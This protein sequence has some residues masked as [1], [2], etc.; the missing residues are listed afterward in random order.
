LTA[1]FVTPNDSALFYID[2]PAESQGKFCRITKKGNYGLLFANISNFLWYAEP[3][4]LPCNKADFTIAV[5]NKNGNCITQL[6]AVSGSGPLQ[7]EVN[8]MGS[9][10]SFSGQQLIELPDYSSPNAVV[11][12]T[13]GTDCSLTKRVGDDPKFNKSKEACAS[14]A[15]LPEAA[16]KPAIYPNPSTGIFNCSQKNGTVLTADEIIISNAQ[17][18]RMGDFKNVQQFNLSNV[19]AGLYWYKMIIKGEE[20]KGKLLKL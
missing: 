14:G 15:R 7:W 18:A 20:F 10:Y 13:N 8:D 19:P 2:I 5:I 4:P 9:T 12:F 11:T 6:K 17:G 16:I 1:R 3:K